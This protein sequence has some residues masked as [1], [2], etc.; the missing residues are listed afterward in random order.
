MV[1]KEEIIKD[2]LVI[3]L[4]KSNIFYIDIIGK[5]VLT[6]DDFSLIKQKIK[7]YIN[8]ADFHL[9]TDISKYTTEIKLDVRKE[10]EKYQVENPNLIT[11]S[12]I[13]NNMWNSILLGAFLTIINLSISTSVYSSLEKALEYLESKFNV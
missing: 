6:S 8:Q 5:K 9:I 4:I 10:L 11:N 13:V 2:Y 3:S 1:K 12:V 7:E